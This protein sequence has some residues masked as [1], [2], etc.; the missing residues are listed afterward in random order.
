LEAARE[1]CA[2]VLGVEP[3]TLYFTSGATESNTI[4]LQSLL[5]LPGAAGLAYSLL[6]HPSVTANANVLP[7]FGKTCLVVPSEADG[8]ISAERMAS[9]LAATPG[10]RMAAVMA[11]NNETGAINDL[12]TIVARLR[13][14]YGRSLHFHGDVVQAAGKIPMDLRSWDLDSAALSAHKIGG[15]R[16]IG[17]LYLRK[18][19][20]TLAR[21]GSQET[22]V[23]AGTENV[24][25]A[26]AMAASLER[27]ALATTV[28][29]SHQ[30][31]DQ[32]MA[33]F[34]GA[35]RK[36][37]RCTLIPADRADSDARF[38][39]FILQAAFRGIPGEVMVRS[40]D[41]LGFAVSTGS[42]C[43]SRVYARPVLSAMGIDRRT[44]RE[45]VRFSPGWST[46]DEDLQALTDAVRSVLAALP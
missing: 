33:R 46:T 20:E 41:D 1:R 38:S 25:G 15:P 7:R 27:H 9:T 5:L 44:A 22:G 17:V 35:L 6:E 23:R 37:E 32:R 8:R 19:V 45:G 16:G 4:V 31:A 43:S 28:A 34:I 30:A 21:G 29:G 12:A 14:D 42:A 10:I 11:V 40:L 2:A 26:L 24:T 36:M 18:P 13:R 39:P 3:R